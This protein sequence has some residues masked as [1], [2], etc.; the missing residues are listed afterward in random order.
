MP[1]NAIL[2]SLVDVKEELFIS[3]DIGE[4]PYKGRVILQP[5]SLLV[6]DSNGKHLTHIEV[7]RQPMG[8]IAI[9]VS[10]LYIFRFILDDEVTKLPLVLGELQLS[11][12]SYFHSMSNLMFNPFPARYCSGDILYLFL[13][14]SANN[15]YSN[16]VIG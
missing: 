6:L 14:F 5:G 4:E 9:D 13:V 3:H 12:F 1:I 11:V 15:E 2:A 16:L 10:N 8:H 7:L